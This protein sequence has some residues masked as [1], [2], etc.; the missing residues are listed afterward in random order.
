MMDQKKSNLKMKNESKNNELLVYP[1]ENICQTESLILTKLTQCLKYTFENSIGS[2]NIIVVYPENIFRPA[3]YLSYLFMKNHQKDVLFF[4][5]DIGEREENPYKNHL[6]KFCLLQ[7]EG[8]F[9][10]IWHYYLPCVID[11]DSLKIE[12]IFRKGVGNKDK[13]IFKNELKEKLEDKKV[14][15]NKLIFSKKMLSDESLNEIKDILFGQQHYKFENKL[16]L[17]I[18]ENL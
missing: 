18:F 1:F 10:L 9:G 6:E 4:T 8:R 12:L 2:K 17:C 3:T 16:G 13:G 14:T 5:P 7:E 15:F 11:Q